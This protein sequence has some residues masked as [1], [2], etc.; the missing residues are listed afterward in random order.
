MSLLLRLLALVLVPLQDPPKEEPKAPPPDPF[1]VK[2]TDLVRARL[3]ARVSQAIGPKAK[4]EEAVAA[5]A[6]MEETIV[7]ESAEKLGLTADEVRDAWKKRERKPRKLAYGDGSWIVLGGQDGGLDSDVK[8]RPAES[9]ELIPSGPSILTR[10][11]SPPPAEPVPMG[12]PLQTRDE[13]WATA[14]SAERAAFVEGEFARKS[15]LVEKK[16]DSKKCATCGGKGAL[17]VK[18]G[19]LGLAV[20]CSRCHGAKDDVLLSYE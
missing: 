17:A 6:A 16:E 8:A 10:R 15:S 7:A 3:A 1:V 11:K 20:V 19:G 9:G 12:K 14:T 2:V 5:A 13:W 4:F 18:R